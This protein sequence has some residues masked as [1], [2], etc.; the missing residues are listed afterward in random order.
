[1]LGKKTIVP[2]FLLLKEFVKIFE[3]CQEICDQEK[4]KKT[5]NFRPKELQDRE[6]SEMGMK[7]RL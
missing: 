4:S 1:M 2:N 3:K 7:P 5:R 6:G